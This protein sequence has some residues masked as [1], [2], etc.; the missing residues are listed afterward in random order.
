MFSVEFDA[1]IALSIWWF[2]A[3]TSLQTAMLAYSGTFLLPT[4]WG[5][6]NIG[7]TE[8]EAML[9]G[10]GRN[11]PNDH[12]LQIPRVDNV[13]RCY[14][15]ELV[16]GLKNAMLDFT[17]VWFCRPLALGPRGPLARCL[18]HRAGPVLRVGATGQRRCGQR[19]SGGAHGVSQG[20]RHHGFFSDGSSED[21]A[22]MLVYNL[23]NWWN[24]FVLF[25][26][27][28]LDPFPIDSAYTLLKNMG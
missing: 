22:N 12:F 16:P 23:E 2:Q 21:S 3:V 28:D 8:T 10:V 26:D 11:H 20:E 17:G 4:S 5:M 24:V 1:N 6:P 27:K 14:V 15:C 9:A 7:R 19:C 13:A 25:L 18:R